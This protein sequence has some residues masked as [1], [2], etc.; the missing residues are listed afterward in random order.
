MNSVEKNSQP[1]VDLTTKMSEQTLK[2][3]ETTTTATA[4]TDSNTTATSDT[5]PAPTN[6]K[7]KKKKKKK[8]KGKKIK[9][10]EGFRSTP[11][12]MYEAFTSA[13]MMQAY[14]FAPVE[15]D[16][17][18]GGKFSLFGGSIEGEFVELIADTKISQKWRFKDWEE[19]VY[20]NV[21]ITLEAVDCDTCKVVLRHTNIP[22]D[23]RYGNHYQPKK[24]KEG[25]QNFY[26]TR[27]NKVLGYGKVDL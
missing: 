11:K 15:I 5:P 24:V 13:K 6:E 8:K 4:T 23:D 18:P 2:E 19:G 27:I 7:E 10:V 21:D 14:T 16:L 9:L 3:E 25:W 17:K 26:W 20:S 1:D 22:E 12:L